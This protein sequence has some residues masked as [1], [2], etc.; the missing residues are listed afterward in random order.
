MHGIVSGLCAGPFNS[1][2][3]KEVDSS[4]SVRSRSKPNL[5]IH[6]LTRRSTGIGA[7]GLTDECL[8]IHDLTRRST[9]ESG[10]SATPRQ[11][12]NSR[13]HKE[14]DYMRLTQI[15]L[16]NSFNSRPHKEVDY[17]SSV[18]KRSGRSFNSRPHKEVDRLQHNRW[19]RRRLSIHDLTRRSTRRERSRERPREPF[20]SR[21]HKEV[22]SPRHE[23]S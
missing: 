8:S 11:A 18:H 3:H 20:N 13:P 1:R 5:S 9:A 2:P 10:S 4:S 6:D 21:P 16:R 22:D 17:P 7:S 15:I 14:V 19:R 12:F 23:M